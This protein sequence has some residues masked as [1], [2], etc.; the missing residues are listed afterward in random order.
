MPAFFLSVFRL[1]RLLMSGH[2]AIA[3]ENA[4]LRLQLA[5]LQRKR[6]RPF[7]KGD[8]PDVNLLYRPEGRNRVRRT[9]YVVIHRTRAVPAQF[10]HAVAFAFFRGLERMLVHGRRVARQPPRGPSLACGSLLEVFTVWA[11]TCTGIFGQIT[12]CISQRTS[13]A[14][15]LCL[16]RPNP[17][18]SGPLGVG[19]RPS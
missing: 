7:I 15:C 19:N 12:R 13:S 5:A 9:E 10:V 3:L 18:P 1:V 2:G 11:K 8:P 6:K 4:A 17:R 16:L 14:R